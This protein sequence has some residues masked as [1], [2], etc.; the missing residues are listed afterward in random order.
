MFDITRRTLLAGTGATALSAKA[1][2]SWAQ[3]GGT[4]DEL[5]WLIYQAPG[6]SVDLSTRTLQPG[7]EAVGFKVHLEYAQGAGGRVART[8]LFNAPKDGSVIMT[9]VAPA[10]VVDQYLYSVPY[11]VNSFDPLFGWILNGFHYCVKKDSPIRTFSD[12]VAECKKRRVSVG[13]IGRGGAFHLHIVAM[14]Q[15][16]GLDFN[17]VHFNGSSPAYTAVLGGHV[18]VAGGGAGSGSRQKEVLHFLGMTGTKREKALPDVPTLTELGFK[19][20]PVEQLYFANTSPDTPPAQLKRLQA[21][22]KAT[23]SDAEIVK[24]ME[25]A[26]DYVTLIPPEEI[27]ELH[28]AQ[29][30]LVLQYKDALR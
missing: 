13:T 26:G 14:R 7:I 24:R 11:K 17:I 1:A 23:L 27:H 22:F 8:R 29:E 21:A 20:P 10:A 4:T 5:T 3:G 15:A 12:F 28:K 30:A 19:V 16:L 6:G 18:D 9:E 25:A 2:P